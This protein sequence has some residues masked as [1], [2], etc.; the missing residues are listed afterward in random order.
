MTGRSVAALARR[1]RT[2]AGDL[3]DLDAATAA[4]IE[5]RAAGADGDLGDLV[6]ALVDLRAAVEP[7]TRCAVEADPLDFD[8]RAVAGPLGEART[9]AAR[10]DVFR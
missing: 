5:H 3:R 1:A 6:R 2:L 7:L 8:N 10:G 9:A 4:S